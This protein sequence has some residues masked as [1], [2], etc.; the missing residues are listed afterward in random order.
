MGMGLET[1]QEGNEI[2]NQPASQRRRSLAYTR[3]PPPP[4]NLPIPSVPDQRQVPRLAHP[5]PDAPDHPYSSA[6]SPHANEFLVRQTSYGRPSASPNLTTIAAFSHNINVRPTSAM[7]STVADDLSDPPPYSFLP[8]S[9][10]HGER[11]RRQSG[12]DGLLSPTTGERRERPP[13]SRSALTRALELARQ[14]VH[15]D[16]TNDN[17]AAAVEAYARSVALL[18]QVMERVKRGEDAG[19]RTRSP[20]A[21]EEEVRRLQNIVCVQHLLGLSVLK[22]LEA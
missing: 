17:P 20:E 22:V 21:Q 1:R 3:P 18:S 11:H 10:K 5:T 7:T 12:E 9:P 16:S 19:R 8:S 2:H 6:A 4:P 14:A 15:L 13:S